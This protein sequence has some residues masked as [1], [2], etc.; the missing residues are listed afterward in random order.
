MRETSVRKERGGDVARPRAMMRGV[1]LLTLTLL[2][3]T[4][5]FLLGAGSIGLSATRMGATVNLGKTKLG[6]VLVNAKGHT[7]YLFKKDKNGKSSCNGSCATFWPP[8][9]RHGKL[10]A[11]SGVKASLLGT[12][13]RSNGSLQV[14]YNKQP[15]YTYTVDKKAGQTHGEGILAFGAKW[16][17]VSA[18]GR[19]VP[20]GTTTTTTTS[21]YSYTYGR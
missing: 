17:A 9:L 6:P 2:L 15:L 4:I 10:T 18:K 19:A 14:T 5:G 3:G 16:Y 7:L 1:V 21:T 11:G 12:T 8:L 20:P 13:K